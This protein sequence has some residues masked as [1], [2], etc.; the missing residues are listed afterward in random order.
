MGAYCL[1]LYDAIDFDRVIE[2]AHTGAL[3]FD[4]RAAQFGQADVIPLWVADMDFAAPEAVINALR[5]RAEHP[6]YGYTL[7]PDSAF[8]ALMD[9]QQRIH[10]WSVSREQIMF[11][12]G[13]VP[14]L[15]AA[16]QAFTQPGDAVIIQPPVYF[17]FFSAITDSG[18]RVLENPLR[19]EAGL[20]SIDFAHLQQCA[21]EGAKLLLLCSPH[22]PVGRVWREDELQE[23]LRIAREYDLI[24][25]SDEIHADLIF[26]GHRHIPLATLALANE[27]VIT[28]VA[29]SKTFNIPGL[30]L[31]AL[32]AANASHRQALQRVFDGLHVSASNP[33]SI[34]A[35]TAAYRHGEPW[36]DALMLYL[37][38]TCDAVIAYVEAF[39][40][41]LRVL[42]PEGTYLMWLDCRALGL[43]DEQLPQFFIEHA[44]VGLSPGHIFG[45]QGSGYMRLNIASPR[46]IIMT[47]LAQIRVALAAR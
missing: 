24:I 37:R 40:P 13:V 25:L 1:S 31:S 2:R 18:R 26:D 30:G 23:L 8:S 17:P 6:L 11:C 47:A 19:L 38:A 46:A 12:P 16:V 41:E 4:G 29:P 7:Y 20:Y 35:F 15:Y 33:F 32:I 43:S 34:A 28:A 45:T 14:S 42:A 21:R 5:A 36:R 44:G 27:S 22:N 3:K 39:L 10:D 9:W